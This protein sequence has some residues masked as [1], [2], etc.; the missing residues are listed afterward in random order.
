[1]AF[2]KVSLLLYKDTNP[3][4]SREIAVIISVAGPPV[5]AVIAPPTPLI[6]VMAVFAALTNE[7]IFVAMLAITERAETAVT[8]LKIKGIIVPAF[9]T[10]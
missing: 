6:T 5:R 9:C 2:R 8:I 3:T 7:M 10:I 4:T 1:M